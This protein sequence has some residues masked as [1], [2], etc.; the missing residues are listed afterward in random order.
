MIGSFLQVLNINLPKTSPGSTAADVKAGPTV[1]RLKKAFDA[2]LSSHAPT[3]NRPVSW[4]EMLLIPIQP[5]HG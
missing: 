2:D 4:S 3:F 5:A 1:E